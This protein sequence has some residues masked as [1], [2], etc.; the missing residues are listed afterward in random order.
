MP[1]PLLDP[2]GSG[3][4]SGSHTDY[5]VAAPVLLSGSH[6]GYMGRAA[7]IGEPLGLEP[8]TPGAS[9]GG[10]SGLVS[11]LVPIGT[12]VTQALEPVGALAVP[13]GTAQARLPPAPRP[14]LRTAG[15]GLGS[16][17]LAAPQGGLDADPAVRSALVEDQQQRAAAKERQLKH[18]R[19]ILDPAVG[20]LTRSFHAAID[21]AK[22]RVKASGGGSAALRDGDWVDEIQPLPAG[23]RAAAL[24]SLRDGAVFLENK[25]RAEGT[26]VNRDR[27]LRDWF[28]FC[29]RLGLRPYMYD[30]QDAE[31]LHLYIAWRAMGYVR[32]RDLDKPGVLP[33]IRDA[34]I[35][36]EVSAIRSFH[37]DSLGVDLDEIDRRHK[38]LQKGVTRISG[39]KMARLRLSEQ[40]KLAMDSLDRADGSA[41]SLAHLTA[42]ELGY[43]AMHRISEV[44]VGKGTKHH[45]RHQDVVFAL[46]GDGNPVTCGWTLRSSKSSQ[47]LEVTRELH[48]PSFVMTM[49]EQHRRNEAFLVG[50]TSARRAS[51]PFVQANGKP[52]QKRLVLAHLRQLLVKMSKGGAVSVPTRFRA[53]THCFRRGGARMWLNTGIGEFF[54]RWLGRWRS[55][56]WLIY[57]EVDSGLLA[58]AALLREAHIR[59]IEDHGSRS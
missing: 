54:I 12:S 25:S 19:P 53:G 27:Y 35:A 50:K 21:A 28:V 18:P 55:L 40:M 52:L 36:N 48:S 41:L 37:R 4:T 20:C 47:S 56:A 22:A 51:L 33:G 32:H 44:A 46:D 16:G 45:L 13:V 39:A 23:Q 26:N 17:A 24:E 7:F 34:S 43:T 15:Q 58:K 11:G 2:Y 3:G 6:T 38:Q 59:K 30:R 31:V 5:M 9:S 49:W 10:D 42:R 57:P 1:Y 14:L 8:A 29:R